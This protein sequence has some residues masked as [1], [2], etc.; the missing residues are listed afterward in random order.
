MKVY[1]LQH[2][3]FEGP[4]SLEGWA[5][6]QGHE[7]RGIRLFA[8]ESLPSLSEVDLLVILG[9][10]MS[11]HDEPQLP[12]LARE[13]L[14]VTEAIRQGRCVLGI[15]LGAQ[16]VAE[17][18]GARVVRHAEREIGWFSVWRA[19]GAERSIWG[20]LL[21][22]RFDPLH[23]HGETFGIPAGAVHLAYSLACSAQAFA[24]GDRVLGLQFHLEAT[25]GS[26]A[27]MIEHGSEDLH[28]GP[29]VQTVSGLT[30]ATERYEPANRL[31]ASI[32]TSFQELHQRGSR[33]VNNTFD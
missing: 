14:F 30:S 31:L 6:Q 8:D 19:P 24:Y 11:V 29:W 18:L 1:Y 33:G 3:P 12:W 25:P 2:V 9:G 32:L 4:G 10:P 17:V 20:Q 23:W 28:P 15:C 5:H 21:P 26:V 16:I 13:K 27:V 7:L 22:E